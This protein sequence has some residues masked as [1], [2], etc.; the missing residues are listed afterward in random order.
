MRLE[1]TIPDVRAEAVLRLAEELGLSKS[2]VIDE[3]LSLF[4]MAAAAVKRGGRIVSIGP[5][6]AERELTTP[7]LAAI[8]LALAERS[9]LELSDD[10]I[11]RVRA[12]L[13]E[14]R[15]PGPRL[16]R[17]AKKRP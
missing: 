5:D 6:D 8:E 1:A 13:V 11:E 15:K 16:R 2:Q 14:A 4:L 9:A 7:T 12:L 17:A 10:A 3:A